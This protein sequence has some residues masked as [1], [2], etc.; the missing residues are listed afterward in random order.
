MSFMLYVLVH[1]SRSV[2][3]KKKMACYDSSMVGR[4][5][6]LHRKWHLKRIDTIHMQQ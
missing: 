1:V 6:S 3:K 5:S 2:R 4:D